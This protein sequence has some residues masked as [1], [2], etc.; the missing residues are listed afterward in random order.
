MRR[1][2]TGVVLV[3]LSGACR[4]NL[5][6][7][8]ASDLRVEPRELV[9]GDTRAGSSASLEVEVRNGGRVDREV[10]AAAEAPFFSGEER[11]ELPAGAQVRLL[12]HFRPVAAGEATGTLRLSSEDDAVEIRL[13]GRG[14]E[15]LV[16]PEAT[17]QCRTS[18]AGPMG[19]TELAAPDGTPCTSRCLTGAACLGGTCVGAARSCDDSD[20]CTVDS[21]DPAEGCLH[22]AVACVDPADACRAGR[23]D[24]TTGCST[25]DVPDGT[26]CG[27]ND[28]ATAHVCI[29]GRC[30]E[31]PAP[32]GSRCGA[33]TPCSPAPVCR[34]GR[35]AA[36]AVTTLQPAWTYAVP[37]GATLVFPGVSDGAGNLYWLER[38]AG[39]TDL[40]SFDRG[41]VERLRV[42]V[43][44]QPAPLGSYPI[45]EPSLQLV[46]E[47]RLLIVVQDNSTAATRRIEV[48]STADGSLS[49]QAG[50]AELAPAVSLPAGL[51]LW[52]IS[53]TVAP[54][55]DRVVL[56]LRTNA[57]GAAWTSWIASL[58][59]L[60]GAVQWAWQSR[61]I[62]ETLAD[63]HGGVFA[64][65]TT[66]NRNL[67]ALS[68]SG[69]L[70]WGYRNPTWGTPPVATHS[71]LLVTAYP[72]GVYSTADGG[73]LSESMSVYWGEQ[74]LLGFG[75]LVSDDGNGICARSMV[76]VSLASPAQASATW[77]PNGTAG[78]AA[79]LEDAMLTSRATVLVGAR[80]TPPSLFEVALDGGQLFSCPL[81]VNPGRRSALLDGA[82]VAAS[83]TT[84]ALFELPGLRLAP[85]GWV[86]HAGGRARAKSPQ[87]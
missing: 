32:E 45:E 57:G 48:R 86:S 49:W 37:A 27:T 56:N 26:P 44:G 2:L 3:S 33:P 25:S 75:H 21:C 47:E 15:P 8:A 63:E 70:L 24:P 38:R 29:A 52:I 59:A 77:V 11:F 19:C 65:E 85:R 10:S 14:A 30:A 41:G 31:R 34:E 5:L 81:P 22:T 72:S 43:M 51:P 17:A 60:T 4:P 78:S 55:P 28:C 7:E 80:T 35:C 39:T 13:W 23:C 6:V 20:R 1:L 9:F 64:Y 50:R 18:V 40:V 42:S 87:R 12:V 58:D 82:W 61:Y 83:S 73:Q 36:G 76:M 68:P 84:I 54:N 74:P 66:F 62:E 46:S 53:A 67:Q 71:G 16:C 79:C 69:A